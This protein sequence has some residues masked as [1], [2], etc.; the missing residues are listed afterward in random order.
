MSKKLAQKSAKIVAD[1]K[2][3]LPLPSAMEDCPPCRIGAALD[4]SVKV[5][6]TLKEKAKDFDC[7]GCYDDLIVEMTAADQETDPQKVQQLK[8]VAMDK[9]FDRMIEKVT[10]IDAEQSENLT[11]LK[12]LM[13][14]KD[15]RELIKAQEERTKTMAESYLELPKSE[16]Q[17]AKEELQLNLTEKD[18]EE[19]E[20]DDLTEEDENDE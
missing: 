5:C 12:D 18:G 15:P 6:D 10:P 17:E 2:M 9:Y 13:H 8:I 3:K 11:L 16:P 20:V 4:L 14:G 1:T 19:P 7:K